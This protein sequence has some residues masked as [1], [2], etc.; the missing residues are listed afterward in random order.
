LWR[1]QLTVRQ[2]DG[3]VADDG[4]ATVLDDDS[5]ASVADGVDGAALQHRGREEE[6]C[7]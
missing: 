2:G 7:T 5:E 1:R 6:V 3:E 4:G